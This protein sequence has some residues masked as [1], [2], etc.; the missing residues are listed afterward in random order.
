MELQEH[1]IFLKEDKCVVEYS[2]GRGSF[3]RGMQFTADYP[4]TD[5]ARVRM[6][7][8]TLSVIQAK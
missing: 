3:G 6:K 8:V 5:E 7:E 2:T 4:I 1:L